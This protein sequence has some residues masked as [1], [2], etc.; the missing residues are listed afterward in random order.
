[1]GA[2]IVVSEGFT[3]RE[4][5]AAAVNQAV[6]EAMMSGTLGDMVRTEETECLIEAV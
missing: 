5:L 2:E 3:R 1:M 4:L 6:S